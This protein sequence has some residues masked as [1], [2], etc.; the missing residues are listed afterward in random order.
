MGKWATTLSGS[1][2]DMG[3]WATILSGSLLDMKS[4]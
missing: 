1:L 3:K 4:V 2:L